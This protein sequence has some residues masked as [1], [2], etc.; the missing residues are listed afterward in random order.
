MNKQKKK[1]AVAARCK[2]PFALR[3]GLSQEDVSRTKE[4]QTK[5]KRA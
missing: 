4:L 3:P 2:R 1:K 5:G